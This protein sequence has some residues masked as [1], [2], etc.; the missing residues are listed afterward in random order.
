MQIFKQVF[1]GLMQKNL[2]RLCLYLRLLDGRF[3]A[4]RSLSVFDIFTQLI[5]VPAVEAVLRNAAFS[6][7]LVSSCIHHFVPCGMTFS[8]Y[9]SLSAISRLFIALRSL[10]YWD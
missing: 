6:T 7:Y 5:A 3:S 4:W 9:D 2:K 10:R 8:L 1:S